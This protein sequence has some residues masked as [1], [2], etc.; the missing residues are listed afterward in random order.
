MPIQL[1][2]LVQRLM[3]IRQRQ[4]FDTL[5]MRWVLV[6]GFTSYTKQ[7]MRDLYS[8]YHPSHPSSIVD[9]IEY[10]SFRNCN[11]DGRDG[12]IRGTMEI[13][14]MEIKDIKKLRQIER[15]IN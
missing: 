6:R 4:L 9:C 15:S 5:P 7:R 2:A 12:G 8:W 13:I 10:S 11:T 3:F 14:V 1:E